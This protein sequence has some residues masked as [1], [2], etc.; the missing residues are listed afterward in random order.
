MNN[1]GEAI[2][3]YSFALHP[4]LFALFP[5]I[6]FYG[7]NAK[8]IKTEDKQFATFLF[9][10]LAVAVITWVICFVAT[11]NIRKASLL[12][13]WPI[14][15]FFTFGRITGVM[16]DFSV[17]TPFGLIGP[18]KTL[19][20]ISLLIL[21][22]LWLVLIKLPKNT[23]L[24]KA[25]YAATVIA[26]ILLVIAALPAIPTLFSGGNT[27]EQKVAETN[28]S[29]QNNQQELPDV[30][31]IILDGYARADYLKQ[32]FNYDNSEFINYLKNKGFYVAE[33]AN[34]NYA[35]THLSVPSTFNMKHITYLAD[36]LGAESNDREPLK[37]LTQNNEIIS[38]FKSKG[39]KYVQIG[40]QWS[41]VTDNSPHADIQ[42]EN[43]K[44]QDS[45]ILNIELDEFALVYLQTTAMKP[46][47]TSEIRGTMLS[48]ILGA[49]E[50]TEK[51]VDVDGPKF[52][53]SHIL[54][55]HP[56]YLFDSN[57]IIEGLTPLDIDNHGFSDR[58][59]FKEQTVY[60]N[61]R[62]Q[63]L[64]D[65]ILS[66]TKRKSIIIIASDHGP[67]SGLGR[68]DFEETDPTKL[69]VD[70]IKERMGILN[71]YYFPDQNYEKLYPHITPVNSFRV[72]LSQYFGENLELLPDTSYFS[73][74]KDKQYL[75][76]D[77][78]E[79]IK[80]N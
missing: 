4:I 24:I 73:D 35:H 59:K 76:T 61:Q 66:N 60:V 6:S 10:N 63:T 37:N 26:A 18:S 22:V 29:N 51:A 44:E 80:S 42:I 9:F 17:G 40:S 34:A 11:L 78:T 7:A 67:A 79:L 39:Y 13:V 71:A 15:I 8:E 20:L 47:V 32:N 27:V 56:P 25:N 75:F 57:G 50:K 68:K 45:K 70:A 58:E 77:V 36:E 28:T 49:F 54:S 64:V 48:R 43:D 21:G 53:F 1:L 72:T 69:K 31:Y 65:K 30:Y 14:L 74:N 23:D 12:A 52:T 2:K 5:L 62:M 38:K 16:G 3:K 55:P 46:L 41:W 33:Q 19:A